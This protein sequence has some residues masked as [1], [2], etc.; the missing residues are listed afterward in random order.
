[1]CEDLFDG[2]QVFDAGDGSNCTAACGTGFCVDI[3]YR[4]VGKVLEQD[5]EA[6]NTRFSRCAQEIGS[7]RVSQRILTKQGT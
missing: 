6:L 1:M 5:A 3:A 2:Y 7:I 4:D